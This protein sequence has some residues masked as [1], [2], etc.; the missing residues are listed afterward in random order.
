M[1]IFDIK[2]LNFKL[3]LIQKYVFKAQCSFGHSIL[4]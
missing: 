3:I 4:V 2:Q 1:C